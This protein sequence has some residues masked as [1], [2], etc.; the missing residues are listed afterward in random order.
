MGNQP[1]AETREP[2]PDDEFLIEDLDTFE[3]MSYPMRT[4]ILQWLIF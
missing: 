3:I 4:T 2:R 1:A